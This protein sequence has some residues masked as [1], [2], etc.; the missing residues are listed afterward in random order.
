VLFL[1]CDLSQAEARVVYARSKDPELV[2][3][4]Q[5]KPWEYDTHKYN[6]S[7]IFD[8]PEFGISGNERRVTKPVVHGTHYWMQ[9]PRMSDSLLSEGYVFT[10][11]QCE[12]FQKRY[13]TARPGVVKWQDQTIQTVIE[14]KRLVNSWGRA[15]EFTYDRQD[16]GLYRRALAWCP[17]GDIGDLTNQ[18]GIIPLYY[19]IKHGGQWFA[20]PSPTS[21]AAWFITEEVEASLGKLRGRPIKSRINLQVHDEI[22][23]SCPQD[24]IYWIARFLKSSL[25]RNRIYEGTSLSIPLEMAVGMNSWHKDLEYKKFPDSERPLQIATAEYFDQVYEYETK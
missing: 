9:P 13:L 25:E 15:I 11:Q 18:W 23:T 24:E 8:K 16:A 14:K 5:S 3:I 12:V 17:Q 7:I 4:A 21:Q 22:V 20:R 1:Q 19:E 10:P 2:T 6:A